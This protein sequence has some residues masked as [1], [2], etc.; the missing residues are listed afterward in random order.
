VTGSCEVVVQDSVGIDRRLRSEIEGWL[1]E[2]V[3]CWAPGAAT[4]GVR[5]ASSRE[6][7]ELNARL[8]GKDRATD[9]LS[10]PGGET[11]DGKHLGD[12]LVAVPVA[13][14]QARAA[15]HGLDRELKELLLHGALHC[16][17]HDHETDDGEMVALELELRRRWIADD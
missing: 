7:R 11:P 15:G 8:R 10:F 4:F 1:A 16:L 14:A 5:L 3:P 6:V 2:A 12:V 17:G 9:V 13:E